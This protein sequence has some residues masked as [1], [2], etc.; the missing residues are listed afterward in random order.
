MKSSSLYKW[1]QKNDVLQYE[2]PLNVGGRYSVLT[3]VGLVPAALM[4]LDLSAFEKGA[5]AALASSSKVAQFVAEVLKSFERDEYI[6]VLWSYSSRYKKFGFWW[7][8]LWA[9]SLAKTQSQSGSAAKRVSTPMWAIGSSD[10]HSL[11]QQVMDGAK[12]KFVIFQRVKEI[13]EA[14]DQLKATQFS[15]QDF[16]LGHSMGQLLKA[17][18]QGTCQAL[19]EH[20]ISTMTLETENTSPECLGA[21]LL[22][23]QLVVASVAEVL[24]I[25]AFDQPGVELGKRLAKSILKS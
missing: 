7:Q 8:Q 24:D 20:K 25:N 16:F 9:E 15:N 22:F 1:A 14:G 11:L 4:G 2:I 19:N 10:Q 5:R 21:Q 3:P 17:Q 23:W 13:E 6:T 12:D 18:A